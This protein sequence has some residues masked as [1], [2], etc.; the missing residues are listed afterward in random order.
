MS[1]FISLNSGFA[2][3]RSNTFENYDSSSPLTILAYDQRKKI[4]KHTKVLDEY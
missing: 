3:N 1:H 2:T 4:E